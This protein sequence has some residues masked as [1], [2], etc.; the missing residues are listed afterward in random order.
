MSDSLFRLFAVFV[1]LRFCF[2]AFAQGSEQITAANLDRLRSAERINFDEY[3]DE[4]E[5]GWFEANTDA[6][7]FIVFERAGHLYRVGM[8]GIVES[9]SYRGDETQV[10]SLIDAVYANDEPYVLYLL[11]GAYFINDRQLR[12]DDFPVA[13][14]K[15][16][17]SLFVEAVS[18]QGATLYHEV[19]L[20]TDKDTIS[21]V[22][23]LNLPGGD[24]DAPGV[25]IGR[26]DFPLVVI[27]SLADNALR[28]YRYPN[29]FD[30]ESASEYVLEHGP[31]V[32]G[33][34]N[35]TGTFL[36]WSDP[37]SERLNHL[38]FD[39]GDN[40]VIAELGGSYA[41]YH[42]LTAD[43]SAIFAVNVDFTPKVYAWDVATG[44]QYDLGPY[45][46]CTRIPDKVILSDDGRALII[47][48]DSG[49]D[50]WRVEESEEG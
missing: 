47:G 41:Q 26:I 3:S 9:W 12:M 50:I 7:E 24:L 19:A 2:A 48:C 25:L 15:V 13:V 20:E 45:R 18:D 37:A 14:Y 44:D 42:L 32:S 5:I 17:R 23:T 38:E 30:A 10:F 4:L 28:V 11:D 6:S 22:R 8:T 27:S 1:A 35:H 21:P 31:A 34:V 43:A 29:S 49:L 40:R 33:A 36:A 39:S 46:E 16:D